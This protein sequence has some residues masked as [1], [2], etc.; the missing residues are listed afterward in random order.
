MEQ[1]QR[2][3]ILN[4]VKAVLGYRTNVRDELLFRVIDSVVDELEK[5]KGVPFDFENNEIVMYVADMTVFR[6][7]N[8]G[9]GAIPRNLDYRL[10]NLIV[11][12]RKVG[13]VDV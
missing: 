9:G 10:K 2:N 4:L 12:Y 11:K 8:L 5:V 6:Y 3:D 13:E 7:Q 1:Q